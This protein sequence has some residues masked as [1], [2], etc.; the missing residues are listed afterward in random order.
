MNYGKIYDAVISRARN[1]VLDGYRERHHILPVCLGGVDSPSNLV[2]LTPEE[3]FF[4]HI[5]LVKIFPCE[6]H[7]IFAVNRMTH[8]HNGK[9][10]RR[11]LYGWL[12]RQFSEAISANQTGSGN[13]QFGSRWINDGSVNKKLKGDQKFP[14]GWH[15][16]KIK[17]PFES[18]LCTICSA[19]TGL[20]RAQFCDE[21]RTLKE[22]QRR[23]KISQFRKS[24]RKMGV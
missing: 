8:G 14:P 18:S 6:S 13:S 12:K 11:K 9:R 5:L 10:V 2:E 17:K 20:G 22:Q 19:P 3:H 1:R 23:D 16:G 4:C 24:W 15:L 7:L 21:H